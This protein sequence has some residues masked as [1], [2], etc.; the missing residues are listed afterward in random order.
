MGTLGEK[1]RKTSNLTAR[2]NTRGPDPRLGSL[3]ITIML[4]IL[5]EMVH[6]HRRHGGKSGGGGGGASGALISS[7]L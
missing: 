2:L 4:L 3:M 1:E 5:V 6:G 7:A